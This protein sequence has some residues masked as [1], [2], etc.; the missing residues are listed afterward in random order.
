ML[1]RHVFHE[2]LIKHS[3]HVLCF[4]ILYADTHLPTK[5]GLCSLVFGYSLVVIED[6]VRLLETNVI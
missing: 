1:I 2:L 4:H 5:Y 3:I 6:L